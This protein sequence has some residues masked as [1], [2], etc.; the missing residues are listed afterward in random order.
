LQ[1]NIDI[2]RQEAKT[3]ADALRAELERVEVELAELED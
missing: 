2:A 3:K 1:A